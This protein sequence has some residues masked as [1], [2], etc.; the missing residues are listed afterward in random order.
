VQ[1]TSVVLRRART[2]LA[3]HFFSSF[4]EVY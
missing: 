3:V 1:F 2:V 4:C